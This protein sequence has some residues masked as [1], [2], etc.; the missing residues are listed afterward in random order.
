[1]RFLFIGAMLAMAACGSIETDEVL[2]PRQ[3]LGGGSGGGMG[4]VTFSG[5]VKPIL[6]KYCSECHNT[7]SPTGGLDVTDHM[8]IT[9]KVVVPGDADGSL[10]IQYL[11]GGVMPPAGKARPTSSEIAAIRMWVTAGAPNN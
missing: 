10:M 8:S 4:E 6:V 9:M 1:M 3:A 11:E 5:T 7:A 2:A